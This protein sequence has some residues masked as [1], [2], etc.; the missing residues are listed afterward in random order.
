[1]IRIFHDDFDNSH[2]DVYVKVD[3]LT[4]FFRVADSY[5]LSSFLGSDVLDKMNWWQNTSI[6]SKGR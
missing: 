1:M 4:T 3:M 6:I 5:Y 2:R